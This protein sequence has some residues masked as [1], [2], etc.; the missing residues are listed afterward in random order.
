MKTLIAFSA[1]I[2]I[3]NISYSQERQRARDLGIKPGILAPGPLNAITD[4]EDVQV[5]HSTVIEGEH[6]RTGVTIIMPHGGDL[7]KS[8][9]P[10]AVYVGNGFGKALGFTQIR[11]LGEIET[12][13]GLTNTLSIH[14]V[15]NGI[16]DYVLR[17]PGNENVRSVNPVVGETNDGWLNDI[18]ARHVTM[19]HVFKAIESAKSGTVAEGSVGAGTGTSALGFKGGIGTSSRQLPKKFGGYTVGVLVQSN[20]GGVLTINGAPVGEELKN[21]YM[22]SDIPYDVDGSIMII[23][24]TDAPLLSRNLERLAKRALLG[25][26]RVGGFASNGSGDYVIAF[27][28]SEDVRIDTR[29]NGSTQTY[30]ELENAATTPLFL[31]A[32]EATEEAILNSLFMATTVT[33]NRG[34]TQQ[35]LPI[36]EVLKVMKKYNLI[37]K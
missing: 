24:A 2:L 4:V 32:V 36:A 10:A 16:T 27:S 3:A 9:V 12:P 30:T 29:K 13:I 11:E 35:A 17:Q 26:A 8:R 5:G 7:F 25:I 33:G 28:T 19:D 37:E 18:R 14:T 21:H 6:I 23:V 34:H 15:A 20:F 1:F 31:A 22:A